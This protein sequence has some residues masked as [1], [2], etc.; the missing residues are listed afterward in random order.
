MSVSPTGRVMRLSCAALVL[1]LSAC[2]GGS[3]N[4]S[5]PSTTG[6]KSVASS[7]STS[8]TV[9]DAA[10]DEARAKSLVLVASDI[11]AGWT[12]SVH[13]TDPSDAAVSKRLAD[14]LGASDPAKMTADVNGNDFD[15]GD[16]EIS[17]NVTIA[18]SRAAFQQDIA[19]ITGPKYQ[20]C[21]KQ[22]L[23]AELQRQLQQSS[24]G[25][26]VTSTDLTSLTSP[27]YG[28]VTVAVRATVTVVAGGQTIVFFIDDYAYGRDR[29]EANVTFFNIAAPFDAALE[30]SLLAK[31]GGKLDGAV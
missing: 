6:S 20:P 10:A 5:E 16:A 30:K 29:A 8:T 24:P 25:A 27:K 7:T 4:K 12:P 13:Q 22:L 1:A 15:K 19:A 17:S 11:P 14:C 2:G 3:K 28:E 31:A 21:I 26:T 18:A 9:P 23:G